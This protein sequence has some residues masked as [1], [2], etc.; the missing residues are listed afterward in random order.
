MNALVEHIEEK[1][2][3]TNVAIAWVWLVMSLEAEWLKAKNCSK[4][5]WIQYKK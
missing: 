2:N 4:E 3:F 5:Q 1:Y